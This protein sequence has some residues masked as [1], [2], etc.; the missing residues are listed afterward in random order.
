MLV[1]QRVSAGTLRSSL[2]HLC[3]QQRCGGHHDAQLRRFRGAV[4]SEVHDAILE[5]PVFWLGMW[6]ITKDL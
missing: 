5:I 2:Q 4:I 6:K 1:Y 3:H